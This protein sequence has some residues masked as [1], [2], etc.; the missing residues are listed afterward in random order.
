MDRRCAERW[1]SPSF[2]QHPP[3]PQPS[4]THA[5]IW[6]ALAAA[7]AAGLWAERTRWGKEMSGALISTLLGLA[8]SNLGV[9]PSESAVY[10]TVNA[11]LL[12]LAVPLLLFS[13]DLRWGFGPLLGWAG[14]DG[15]RQP[16]AMRCALRGSLQGCRPADRALLAMPRR[17]GRACIRPP[18][19]RMVRDTGRL[20]S[21]FLWGSAATVAGSLLAFKLLPLRMLGADGWKVAAA[22]TA[23]HIGGRCWAARGAAACA[24]AGVAKLGCAS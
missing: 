11:Y 23:R 18:C 1:A 8:L 19:R 16:V 22:L 7:G 21:A 3:S 20:L 6:A 10:S 12:P 14:R 15:A 4:C 24:A 5:G 2:S 13:A 9:I 17:L